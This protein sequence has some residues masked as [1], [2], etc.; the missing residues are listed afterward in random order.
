LSEEHQRQWRQIKD[1][2]ARL[3]RGNKE[4]HQQKNGGSH[5]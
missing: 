5:A 2:A 1:H 3:L 4:N